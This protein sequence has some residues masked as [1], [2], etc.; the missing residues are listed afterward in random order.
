MNFF[1]PLLYQNGSLNESKYYV[2]YF[3]DF[4]YTDLCI[5]SNQQRISVDLKAFSQ[6]TILLICTISRW[7]SAPT[8]GLPAS[9]GPA[10]ARARRPG[11]RGQGRQDADQGRPH[12]AQGPRHHP[13]PQP[14]LQTGVHAGKGN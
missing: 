9:P 5:G 12:H 11:Q 2:A 6:F 10:P 7:R 1:L 13:A 4:Y 8:A 14:G 3:V